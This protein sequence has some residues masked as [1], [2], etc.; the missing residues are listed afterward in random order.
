MGTISGNI[1]TMKELKQEV[2]QVNQVVQAVQ[3]ET[4]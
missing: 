1:L 4:N 2:K 3:W